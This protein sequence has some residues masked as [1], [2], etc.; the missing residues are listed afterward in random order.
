[1]LINRSD[2]VFGERRLCLLDNLLR[3]M[4][5]IIVVVVAA[6][7]VVAPLIKLI[8]IRVQEATIRIYK[9]AL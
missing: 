5:N 8:A 4:I 9:E 6:K 2:G 3:W 7:L 1:M